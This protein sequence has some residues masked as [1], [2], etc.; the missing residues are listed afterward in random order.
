MSTRLFKMIIIFFEQFS[1]YW[2]EKLL[3]DA[4]RFGSNLNISNAVCVFIR[5]PSTVPCTTI[6]EFDIKF[7]WI[8]RILSSVHNFY[9]VYHDILCW[10]K[11]FKVTLETLTIPEK[12]KNSGS[13]RVKFIELKKCSIYN[14]LKASLGGLK[15]KV[16]SHPVYWIY[17]IIN[18]KKINK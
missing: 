8:L 13:I 7:S 6:V 2:D 11:N 9:F 10:F 12:V 15:F 17:I 1:K 4:V 5:I 16:E 3:P 14:S 18:C